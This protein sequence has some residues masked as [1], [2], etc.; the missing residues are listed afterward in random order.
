MCVRNTLIKFCWV[1]LIGLTSSQAMAVNCQRATTPL[2]NTICSNDGLHWL[3]TT[4]TIIYR[5]MLVKEDSLKVHRQYEN[6]EKSLEKCTS[7]NCI[8]RAYYEGIS[9]L[10]DADTNFQW[11]GQWWN[12]SAGNMSGG[13]VQ[14]SRNN[15]WGF[16][17]D[18]HAWTGMNGDEYT[19]EARKLYGIG[20]VDRVTDTSNCKLLLIPKKDGS[21]QIH[22]NADWGCRMSMPDGV[23]IDGKY[24]KAT[25]DPR[26]KPSLLSIGIITEAARDQQFRELVGDDYQRFVDTANVYIYSEDLDNIGAR[27]VSMWVRGAS[28]NKA[29]IIMYTPEGDMWAGLIVPD[30][31]GQLA[32]RY[33]SSKNKD[34][35]MMPRTLASWKLHFLEK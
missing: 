30:K 20:I 23:Y 34:E 7:D 22:S 10:S 25:K 17:I 16:N 28:N 31:N 14:F 12:L 29:A 27:V 15:E 8:E 6:W 18:I 2:E 32:M 35:K 4:M 24:T 21:L 11:D 1:L 5:A 13:T 3:D 19:A 9:T 33:Y 26:P